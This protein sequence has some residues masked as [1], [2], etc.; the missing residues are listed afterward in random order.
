MDGFKPEYIVVGAGTAGC[1]VAARLVE[2]GY[3]VLLIEQGSDGDDDKISNAHLSILESLWEDRNQ[4]RD[5]PMLPRAQANPLLADVRRWPELMRGCTVGGSGAVNVMIHTR[6]NAQDFDAWDA[7]GNPGWAWSDVLPYFKSSERWEDG[8]DAYRGG[9]GPIEVRRCE[10]S[11][12]AEAL[13]A[14]AVEMGFNGP[15]WD[16]NGPV[17]QG[18]VGPYQFAAS[19]DMKRSSTASTY[20]AAVKDRTDLLRIKTGTTVARIAFDDAGGKDGAL[21]ATGVSCIDPKLWIEEVIEAEKG[22]V[23]AAG[24]VESPKLMMLSGIGPESVTRDTGIALRHTLSGVGQNLQDHVI[25]QLILHGT[26]PAPE[27]DFLTEIGL[28]VDVKATEEPEM[29][30][31]G[32]PTVQYFMNAGIPFRAL[33]WVTEDYF[34]IYPSLARPKTTGEI[35]L[36]SSDPRRPPLIEMNYLEHPD[37]RRMMINALKIALAMTETDALKPVFGGVY[38]M[39]FGETPV[40]LS[41][42][43]PDAVWQLYIDS[44]TRGLWHPVGTCR[45]GADPAAGAVVDAS[46]KVHGVD[47]LSICDASIFPQITCGNTNATVIMIA[48]KFCAAIPAANAHA[49]GP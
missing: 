22:V 44:Y 24:A 3:R 45:M 48:E 16:L 13:E 20:L 34:G 42:E 25:G 27:L 33:P 32:W 19:T 43:T 1:V 12:Y 2:K 31:E 21:R 26:V 40:M 30:P 39:R 35:R 38:E 17:Q 41:P 29:D 9:D 18:G 23:I 6:G 11:V 10:K 28:Y 5:Y 36:V 49:S 47:G 7:L 15:D 8:A 14:A 37:D 46:L 4:I